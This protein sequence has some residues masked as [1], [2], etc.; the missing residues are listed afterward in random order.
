MVVGGGGG[1]SECLCTCVAAQS[2]GSQGRRPGERS[3]KHRTQGNSVLLGLRLP[4]DHEQFKTICISQSTQRC[5]TLGIN[6]SR[7]SFPK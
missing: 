5:A 4:R 2:L 1:G 3:S 6:T 7:F